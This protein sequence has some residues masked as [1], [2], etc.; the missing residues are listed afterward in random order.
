MVEKCNDF[1]RLGKGK[2]IYVCDK[3]YAENWES[4]RPAIVDRNWPSHRYIQFLFEN[5]QRERFDLPSET[6]NGKMT[7]IFEG[8][9]ENS[10]AYNRWL[11]VNKVSQWLRSAP[12][13]EGLAIIQLVIEFLPG[14]YNPIPLGV[15]TFEEH[16]GFLLRLLK[17][18]SQRQLEDLAALLSS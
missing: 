11:A 12:E 5:G 3:S 6:I 4:A 15:L 2:R 7:C 10:A 14:N 1:Q 8:N 16:V 18:L 17:Y 13:P 9:F